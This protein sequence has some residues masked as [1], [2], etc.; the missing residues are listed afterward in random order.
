MAKL[1]YNPDRRKYPEILKAIHDGLL[2]FMAQQ[3]YPDEE[4]DDSLY[5][6]ETGRFVVADISAGTDVVMAE[7]DEFYLNTVGRFPFTAYNLGL[8][9]ISDNRRNDLARNGIYDPTTNS[10][11]K[12][13]PKEIEI[14]MVS[15]F[16]EWEDYIHASKMLMEVQKSLTRLTIPIL[17]NNVETNFP[18]DVEIEIEKGEYAGAFRSWLDK[19][20]IQDIVHTI[21]IKYFDFTVDYENVHPV[22]SI[23]VYL[24]HFRTFPLENPVNE[25]IEGPIDIV[26]TPEINNTI[27]SDESTDIPISPTLTQIAIEFNV[28]MDTESVEFNFDILPF[29]EGK[30]SW[31]D[32][33]KVVVFTPNENLLNNTNYY[34]TIDK[35]SKNYVGETMKEDFEFSFTTEA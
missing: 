5:S 9:Y 10:I 15:F 33:N 7:A 4:L 25:L 18:I 8:P 20:K 14:Q 32:E 31:D 30:F 35:N 16:T 2:I 1:Y 29:V 21:L 24:R 6:D 17:M 28:S 26:D 12:A 34:I 22:E 13:L 27:P 19:G 3:L 23:E 11:L